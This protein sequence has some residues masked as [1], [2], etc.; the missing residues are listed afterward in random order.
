MGPSLS[1]R[2]RYFEGGPRRCVN[3]L[4]PEPALG[5]PAQRRDQ[6]VGGAGDLFTGS[7]A[8]FD[9]EGE[10]PPARCG[11]GQLGRS[12]RAGPAEALA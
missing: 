5:R 10:R 1:L 9:E 7:L 12:T 6:E 11:A 8:A 4:A 2:E 3:L